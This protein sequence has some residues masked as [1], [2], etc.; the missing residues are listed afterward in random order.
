MKSN[1]T[2]RKNIKL[3]TRRKKTEDSIKMDY[4]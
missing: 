1:L 3:L 2:K 4:D